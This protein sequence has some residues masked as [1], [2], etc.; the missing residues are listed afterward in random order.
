MLTLH[1]HVSI[2]KVWEKLITLDFPEDLHGIT[3][4]KFCKG[5]EDPDPHYDDHREVTATY[6]GGWTAYVTLSSGQSNYFGWLSLR[7]H[8]DREVFSTELDSYT[9]LNVEV[10]G[11]L[12]ALDVSWL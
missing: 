5:N 1:A 3:S 7:D 9:D 2:P 6:A 11:I 10:D 8:N 12:Y 4:E